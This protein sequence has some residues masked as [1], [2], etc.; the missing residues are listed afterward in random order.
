VKTTP[1]SRKARGE[2]LMPD[3]KT[4]S[5]LKGFG[6]VEDRKNGLLVKM[7]E[8]IPTLIKKDYEVEKHQSLHRQMHCHCL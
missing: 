1:A 8:K 5:L 7:T 2:Q 6:G 3:K 4:F